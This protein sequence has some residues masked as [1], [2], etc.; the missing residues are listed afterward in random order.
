[1][2]KYETTSAKFYNGW[3]LSGGFKQLRLNI[4]D[5][6]KDTANLGFYS[7]PFPTKITELLVLKENAEVKERLYAELTELGYTLSEK[8]SDII[9]SWLKPLEP[10]VTEEESKPN[11]EEV[12]V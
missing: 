4:L 7:T 8:G 1:M 11:L 3:A 2:S 5:T 6:V 10:E 12:M 9:I